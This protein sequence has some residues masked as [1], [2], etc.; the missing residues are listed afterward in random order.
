VYTTVTDVS[1]VGDSGK[2]L[3]HSLTLFRAGKVYDYIE[4]VGEVVIFEPLMH[5]FLILGRNY[6]AT[7]VPIAELNQFLES[8]RTESEEYIEKLSKENNP[9]AARLA[10]RVQ[11]QLHPEF[12]ESFDE[13][14]ERLTLSGTAL[15]YSVKTAAVKSSPAVTQYLEYADWAA[16][17]N[18]VLH[19]HS[20][21]PEARL[22]LNES[23]RRRGLL[24]TQVDLTLQQD[25]PVRLRVDHSY[26]WEFQPVDR[27]HIQRWEKM[28]ESKQV[29]W[30]TFPEYQQT[31]VAQKPKGK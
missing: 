28:L 8:A 22:K 27:Q 7:E 26:A 14:T 12:Q 25:E 23:L 15:S 30:M 24:P 18:F 10:A 13:G 16:R 17:L 9:Q 4:E 11:F 5:R 20:N 21:Y 3:S 29:R 31:L 6:S 2:V 19:S 1:R